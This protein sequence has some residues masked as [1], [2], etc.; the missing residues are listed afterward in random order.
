[1]C[2]AT[3]ESSQ[4]NV[5][6]GDILGGDTGQPPANVLEKM[7]SVRLHLDPCDE[8]NGALQ[9]LS[10]SHRLGRIPEDRIPSILRDSTPVC[11]VN[12]GGALLMRSLLLHA[13]SSSISPA[14][15]RVIHLDFAT[16]S[17]P[18]P[19]EWLHAPFQHA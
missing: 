17:L 15:R 7:I 10:G 13:S 2:V 5:L 9:V 11:S 18:K 14:H 16:E 19:L 12:R 1:M 4:G 6:G 8:T 3:L